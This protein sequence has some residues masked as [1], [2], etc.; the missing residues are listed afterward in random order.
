MRTLAAL[1][2]LRYSPLNLLLQNDHAQD[3]HP[4]DIK[5][6][7]PAS[8]RSDIAKLFKNNELSISMERELFEAV[9]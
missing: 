4:I 6:C 9:Q 7:A 3:A 8:E 1:S 5:V 2:V